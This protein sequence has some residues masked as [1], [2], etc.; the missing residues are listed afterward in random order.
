MKLRLVSLH[1]GIIFVLWLIFE[2][3]FRDAWLEA[4]HGVGTSI[5]LPLSYLSGVVA[6]FAHGREQAR[7]A[8]NRNPV[9]APAVRRA[10]RG[11]AVAYDYV[12]L[13]LIPLIIVSAVVWG[14]SFLANNRG[15][16]QWEFIP[17]SALSLAISLMIGVLVARIVRQSLAS[18][19]LAVVL[20][21]FLGLFLGNTPPETDVWQKFSWFAFIIAAIYVLICLLGYALSAK[22]HGRVRTIAVSCALLLLTAGGL[23]TKQV[24]ALEEGRDFYG[25]PVCEQAGED[26]V[27]VWPEDSYK[28]PSLVSMAERARMLVEAMGENPPAQ[29]YQEQGVP[30]SKLPSADHVQLIEPWGSPAHRWASAN[31]FL[32]LIPYS[33]SE[34]CM[35]DEII[36]QNA[37]FDTV[38]TSWIYGDIS[39]T[40]F[41]APGLDDDLERVIGELAELSPED[42]MTRI[43]GWIRDLNAR[44]E[45]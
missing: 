31:R 22:L 9:W 36:H 10:V 28:L 13:C 6:L 37:V 2:F 5:F 27:C 45:Q 30:T 7:V 11:R 20:A 19:V 8:A 21:V 33:D 40:D 32:N 24:E 3:V 41:S 4:Y 43:A 14:G 17:F 23:A 44:C 34:A 1:S 15:Y 26:L 12:E 39:Y 16:L 35:S 29:T 42:Q 18:A 38:A 25:D